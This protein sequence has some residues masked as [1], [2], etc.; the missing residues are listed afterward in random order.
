MGSSSSELIGRPLHNG[1][2]TLA[3]VL[4]QQAADRPDHPAIVKVTGDDECEPLSYAQL[5]DQALALA[6]W[7]DQVAGL[8]SGD[9]VGI[10]LDNR[11][12]LE[13]YTTIAACWMGSFVA[14]PMNARLA[15]PELAYQIALSAPRVIVTSGDFQTVLEST[16]LRGVEHVIDVHGGGAWPHPSSGFQAALAEALSISSLTRPEPGTTCA[17]IFTSGT[18]GRP[19]AAQFQHHACVAQGQLVGEGLRLGPDARLMLAVPV[20]TST[21]IHT[22][23]L[24]CFTWGTTMYFEAAFDAQRWTTRAKAAAPTIYFGVPSMLALILDSGGDDLDA[25]TSLRH[26]MFGGSPMP[27][28]LAERLLQAFP[29]LS[30]WNLYGLT[31]AGPNGTTLRPESALAKL[32]TVGTPL[33]GTE[34]R[35]VGEDGA[36]LPSG[37]TGEV[38]M[39]TPSLM[40]GYFENPEATAATI[41]RDG[42]LH[43]GDIGQLDDEGFLTLVDRKHD[44]IVRGGFNIYP[45]EV[46]RVLSDHPQVKDTAVVGVGHPIL[47]EDVVGCVVLRDGAETT[48]D[49]LIAFCRARLADYKA[50]RK[51]VCVGELPRNAMGKVLRRELRSNIEAGVL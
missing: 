40:A 4:D 15:P 50:P 34:V 47:G 32:S 49:E 7:L 18:T 10:V 51:I 16:D 29:G 28:R 42:W 23:P 12:V 37:D 20:Y 30:L 13:Y 26:V 22:F 2:K 45:A 21:G 19:K 36:D 3:D 33:P 46:E 48:S 5:R 24:P 35:V 31:E 9:T 27:R 17:L 38:L 41:S 25:I 8:R 11:S 44:M 6:G 39:R 14:V 1:S 43:T